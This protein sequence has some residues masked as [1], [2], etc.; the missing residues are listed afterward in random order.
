MRV[1]G[2]FEGPDGCGKS[3]LLAGVR[4]HLTDRGVPVRTGPG[5]GAFL[6]TLN[7]ADAFRD[8]VL[9]SDGLDVAATLLDAAT[10]R[11]TQLLETEHEG[12]HVLL[13]DRGP[14]TV[15]FS[16][17]AHGIGQRTEPQVRAALARQLRALAA[18]ER[19]AAKQVP[20]RSIVI[21]P[22]LGMQT[23]ERRLGTREQ[24]SERY[25]DY[26]TVLHDQF[27]AHLPKGS[28][29]VE[30]EGVLTESIMF[31][32]ELLAE[33]RMVHISPAD[34]ALRRRHTGTLNAV[35]HLGPSPETNSSGYS[36]R[37]P[38]GGFRR[39]CG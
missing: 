23:I 20:T 21:L 7:S 26:L 14:L 24:I 1:L 25:H 30:A 2:V 19:K 27:Q 13:L 8:W 39:G 5:L 35:A 4:Q 12:D 16:A 15:K 34:S 11:L 10:Q 9:R 18:A 37:W 33:L 3:T 36:P 28:Y 17:I 38:A 6:P 29:V 32:R 22:S 31:A